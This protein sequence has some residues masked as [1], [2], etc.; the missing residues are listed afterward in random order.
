MLSLYSP[1]SQAYQWLTK[2]YQADQS[3]ISYYYVT[4]LHDSFHSID[5]IITFQFSLW[6]CAEGHEIQN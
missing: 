3:V 1:A 5:N 6:L 2:S 4:S